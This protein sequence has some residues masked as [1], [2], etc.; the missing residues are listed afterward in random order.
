MNRSLR[1]LTNYLR[2]SEDSK[3]QENNEKEQTI[4]D[5]ARD[6]KLSEL[7]ILNQ[8]LEQ[9]R[10]QSDD[11]YDQLLRLKAEFDNYRKRS[12]VEKRNHKL[13]G[14][15][16][17]LLKQIGLLD[18]LA[19]ALSSAKI[20]QNIDSLIKGLELVCKEFERVL[21]EEG[22]TEVEA[23]GKKFDPTLHEALEQVESEEQEGNI[24]EVLQKGYRLQERLIRPSRVKV[25]KPKNN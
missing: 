13:W 14:K 12:E 11:Y 1:W 3:L 7:E 15:E 9:K 2:I 21:A 19:Q 8:S 18:V 20:S 6:E 10:R 5:A 17:I 16:E 22:L 4:E 25:A 24:V 23:L